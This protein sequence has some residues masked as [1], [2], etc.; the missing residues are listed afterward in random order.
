MRRGTSL[1]E[2]NGGEAP[3]A[4]WSPL[5]PP[6]PTA[7]RIAFSSSI[8]NVDGRLQMR[9]GRGEIVAHVE[10]D[11]ERHLQRQLIEAEPGGKADSH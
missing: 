4:Q 8:V 11:P 9:C 6:W 7:E 2:V 1:S 10:S 3:L 5:H